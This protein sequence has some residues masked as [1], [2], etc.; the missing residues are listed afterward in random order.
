LNARAKREK[1]D[2]VDAWE[3]LT[4]LAEQIILVE[5]AGEFATMGTTIADASRADH[6]RGVQ[7][8]IGGSVYVKPQDM[9]WEPTQFD[10]ISIKVLYEDKEKG[11]MTCFLK[12]EPGATLPMHKHPEI[13]QSYVIEGSFYDHEGVCRAGEFVWRRVGSFHETHSD[14]GAIILAIYR[15]PNVFQHSSGYKR[16]AR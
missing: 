2:E 11:E 1:Q 9:A 10:G 3:R 14:E 4:V 13:E 6:V 12:W 16:A 5:Q 15:K 7:P 8:T